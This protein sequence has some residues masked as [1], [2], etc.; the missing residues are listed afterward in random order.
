MDFNAAKPVKNAPVG[1]RTFVVTAERHVMLFGPDGVANHFG[2]CSQE[3]IED[4]NFA[5]VENTA[6]FYAIEPAS[7]IINAMA[8]QYSI[9]FWTVQGAYTVEL[10]RPALHLHLQ[11]P[12]PAHRPDLRHG[13]GRLLRHGD[14]A[15]RRRLLAF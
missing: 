12:R 15:G 5:S 7:R 9:I 8:A 4:W 3:D 2:W 14:V 1:N 10:P 13:A 11:L 6:G